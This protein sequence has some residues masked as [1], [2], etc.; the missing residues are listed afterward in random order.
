MKSQCAPLTLTSWPSQWICKLAQIFRISSSRALTLT[1]AP[2]LFVIPLAQVWCLVLS[3]DSGLQEDVG[4]CAHTW[5]WVWRGLGVG[6][7]RSREE[8]EALCFLVCSVASL[9]SQ[10]LAWLLKGPETDEP[11]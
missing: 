6:R 7:G 4:V 5:T 8:S 2:D 10:I 3:G 9:L 11:F 1:P